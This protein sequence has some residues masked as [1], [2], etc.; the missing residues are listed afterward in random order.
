MGTRPAISRPRL[1]VCPLPM[2]VRLASGRDIIVVPGILVG[3][4]EG[5]GMIPAGRGP[6]MPLDIPLG[7]DPLGTDPLDTPDNPPNQELYCVL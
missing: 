1:R 3:P 5:V 7:T 6:P 4:A 2:L